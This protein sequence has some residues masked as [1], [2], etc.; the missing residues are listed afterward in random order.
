MKDLKKWLSME[1]YIAK[2]VIVDICNIKNQF[3]RSA[4]GEVIVEGLF[5]S[6]NSCIDIW[7][8]ENNPDNVCI[9]YGNDNGE[10]N[11]TISIDEVIEKLKRKTLYWDIEVRDE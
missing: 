11:L 5:G 2:D 10:F 3:I 8:S 1:Y 4:L 7:Q 6:N 9:F